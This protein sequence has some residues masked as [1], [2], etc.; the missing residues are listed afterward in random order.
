MIGE[1]KLNL[2][3]DIYSVCICCLHPFR[4]RYSHFNDSIYVIMG[5]EDCRHSCCRLMLLLL[6]TH[7]GRQSVTYR[8]FE[9][10]I[11]ISIPNYAFFSDYFLWKWRKPLK[12]SDLMKSIPRCISH[13]PNFLF[14]TLF[15]LSNSFVVFVLA[16]SSCICIVI[17]FKTLIFRSKVRSIHISNGWISIYAFFLLR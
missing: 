13:S 9:I 6:S 1:R 2:S 17:V 4:R 3:S 10:N 16:F 14:L 8:L 5:N 15:L 11:F 12:S 7:F